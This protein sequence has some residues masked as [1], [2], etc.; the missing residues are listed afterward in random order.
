MKNFS[1]TILLTIAAVLV[2]SMAVASVVIPNVFAARNNS[3][4]VSDG[5][6]NGNGNSGVLKSVKISSNGCYLSY[7]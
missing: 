5:D 2:I 6:K 4:G 3:G 1:K 7:C